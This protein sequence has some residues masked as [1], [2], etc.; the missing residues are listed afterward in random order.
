MLSTAINAFIAVIRF[1]LF[2]L[3]LTPT[4]NN[5]FSSLSVKIDDKTVLT[6][7]RYSLGLVLV[8]VYLISLSGDTIFDL[9]ALRLS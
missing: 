6:S 1:L 8:G 7:E 5:S 4:D 2:S 3:N 9:S